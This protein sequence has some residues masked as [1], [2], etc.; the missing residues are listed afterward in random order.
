MAD[1]F[2]SLLKMIDENTS[3]DLVLPYIN[4][5]NDKSPII[6]VLAADNQVANEVSELRSEIDYL[7][8]RLNQ[9]GAVLERY[10][11]FM[12]GQLPSMTIMVEASISDYNTAY[13]ATLTYDTAWFRLLLM[14]IE[15][16]IQFAGVLYGAISKYTL[17]NIETVKLIADRNPEIL[18]VI[19][20]PPDDD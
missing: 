6:P 18:V 3:L 7:N 17:D 15:G 19:N 11:T 12:D 9:V 8:D 10:E 5:A 2:S 13:Q 20:E 16:K 14:S 1:R 4:V